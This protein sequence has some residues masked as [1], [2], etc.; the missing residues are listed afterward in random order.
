MSWL[1]GAWAVFEKDL[2]LELRS[3]YAVNMLLMF[4]LSSLLLVA[5][6]INQASISTRMQA[7]LL[8]IVI[9]FSAAI[10]LGRSFVGEE[11]RGTVLILQLSV[12][13]S[14]VFAGKLVFNF[15]L[16][17]CVNVIAVAVFTFLLSLEIEDMALLLVTLLLGSLGLAGA[18]TMLAAIIARTSNAGPLLP[19]LLF[20]LLVPLLLSVV[21]ASQNALRDGLGWEASAGDLLTLVAFAG[22]VITASVLLFDFVWN[23]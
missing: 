15:F 14:Q 3:R 20:P 8:W 5:F 21:N 9:M 22:V 6:A 17:L 16:L 23:D 19:V 18:T 13:G 4:V 11:E 10:G 12:P 1:N 2:R 7:A